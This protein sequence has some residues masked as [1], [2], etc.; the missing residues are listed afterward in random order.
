MAARLYAS[1]AVPSKRA[2]CRAVGLNEHYLSILSA[3]GNREVNT[4]M[5]QVDRE[6]EDETVALS[7]VLALVSREAAKRM[8]ELIQSDNEHVALRASSDVLDRNPESSKTFKASVTTWSLDS[9][10]ARALAKALVDGAKIKE[11]F[12]PVASTN[13]VRVDTEVGDNGKGTEQKEGVQGDS[14]SRRRQEAAP[15]VDAA[16]QGQAAQ[17]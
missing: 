9:E 10:D 17:G 5:S 6:I 16:A 12:L 8:R 1:G 2:A 13:F 11:Q 7:R 15:D 3:S 14:L 4:L